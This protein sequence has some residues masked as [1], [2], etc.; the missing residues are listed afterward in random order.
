MNLEL[1]QINSASE[2]PWSKLL[3][4]LFEVET[5]DTCFLEVNVLSS[6]LFLDVLCDCPGERPAGFVSHSDLLS[7]Q[8]FFL[9]EMGQVL[10]PMVIF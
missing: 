9:R 2:S 7:N 10:L 8:C 4:S 3:R 6:L 1:K 5:K